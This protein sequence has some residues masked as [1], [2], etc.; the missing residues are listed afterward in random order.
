KSSWKASRRRRWWWCRAAW[1]ISWS[2][3]LPQE[4]RMSRFDWLLTL[5]RA[6]LCGLL[7]SLAGCGFQLRG[8]AQLP[9]DTMYIDMP[10]TNAV[11]AQLARQ[12]GAASNAK[13]VDNRADAQVILTRAY[14]LRNKIILSINSAGR[15]REFR[16]RYTFNY[17]LLDQKGQ[18]VVPPVSIS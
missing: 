1:S 11:A 4:L 12:L 16:L 17:S 5:R 7:F 3:V 2:E 9:F 6:F 10:Q 14:E 18:N 15:V 13:I 8:E